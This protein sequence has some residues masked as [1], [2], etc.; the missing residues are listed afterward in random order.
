[1]TSFV[2]QIELYSL[3]IHNDLWDFSQVP[4]AVL[5]AWDVLV[6]KTDEDPC[7]AETDCENSSMSALFV[8]EVNKC[9]EKKRTKA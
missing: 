2:K 5:Y 8:M 4:T 3:N 7:P 6:N 1:M 9:H